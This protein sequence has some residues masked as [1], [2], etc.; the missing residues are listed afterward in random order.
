MKKRRLV[1]SVTV[2]RST[3]RRGC[4][5]LTCR[6]DRRSA[7]TFALLVIPHG[8]E[9][10][11]SVEIIE[12]AGVALKRHGFTSQR[13]HDMGW[14]LVDYAITDTAKPDNGFAE[15]HAGTAA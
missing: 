8:D 6:L 10:C 11:E 9:R 15:R 12:T 4:D 5:F 3:F 2:V 13:L 7:D 14:V 1:P